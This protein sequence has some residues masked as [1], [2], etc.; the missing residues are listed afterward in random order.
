MDLGLAQEHGMV[1]TCGEG[2][3]C[4]PNT[5]RTFQDSGRKNFVASGKVNSSAVELG[6]SY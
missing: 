5:G 4:F 6:L 3:L 2:Q 1:A